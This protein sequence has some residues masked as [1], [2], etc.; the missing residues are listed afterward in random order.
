M[1][2]AKPNDLVNQLQRINHFSGM[3]ELCRKRNM[4]RNLQRMARIAPADYRFFPRTMLL[5]EETAKLMAVLRG[6][7]KRC[8]YLLKPDAGCQVCMSHCYFWPSYLLYLVLGQF[9]LIRSLVI[10]FNIFWSTVVFVGIGW[11]NV[12]YF[13]KVY[14]VSFNRLASWL[15][16]FLIGFSVKIFC[17]CRL[18]LNGL[19]L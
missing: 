8:T 10:K 4:A 14:P 5:P 1:K 12:I 7:K 6:R 9:L 16:L 18:S 3:L 17:F 13:Y 19:R 15:Y 2:N 11:S